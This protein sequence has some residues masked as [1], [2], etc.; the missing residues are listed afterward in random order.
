VQRQ[1][2]AAG[3]ERDLGI[4]D[5]P[6][7]VF[8]GPYSNLEA[9]QAIRA[10]ARRLGIPPARTIC[11]G[12]IVAYCADPGAT[13]SLIR[14]WGIPVVLGN[15]EESLGAGAEDCACGF[16]PGSVCATLS[17][18][19]YAH[20]ERQLTLDDR[21]WMARLPRLIRFTLA[22]RRL[23]AIHGGAS[24][25]NRWVFA[26]TPAAEKHAEIALANADGIVAGH[27]G[28]PFVDFAGDR[29]WCNAGTVGMPANDGTPRVWYSL[30]TPERPGA[31]SVELQSLDYDY[32]LAAQK[33]RTCGLAQSYARALETGLWPP[34]DIL[35][36][37]EQAAAGRALTMTV[38]HWALAERCAAA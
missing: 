20:A 30:L 17:A 24:R 10:E 19:W 26:S 32:R 33:M 11:T 31:I 34:A 1:V 23:A 6:V 35:P 4:L 29:L 8:G 36:P 21:R 25:I 5:G 37:P 9:A 38:N 22:G 12:D 14:D 15:V 18:Q 13:V 7:L 27:C 28:L 3:A 2:T 16:T